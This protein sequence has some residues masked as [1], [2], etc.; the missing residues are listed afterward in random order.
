MIN[1]VLVGNSKPK[2]AGDNN[3]AGYTYGFLTIDDLK[4]KIN[5]ENDGTFV[6]KEK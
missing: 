4:I 1:S 3:Y 6:I 2:Y 5:K